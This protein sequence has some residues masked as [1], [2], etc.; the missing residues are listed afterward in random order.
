MKVYPDSM[1]SLRNGY[2]I[3]WKLLETEH[4]SVLFPI[5]LEATV[6]KHL[7]NITDLS[8]FSELFQTIKILPT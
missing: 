1:V 4:S 7:Q 3:V 5:D 8:I 6:W 2:N